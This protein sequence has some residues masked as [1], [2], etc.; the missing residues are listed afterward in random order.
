[1]DRLLHRAAERNTLLELDRDV[2]GQQLRVKVRIL[3][4]ADVDL[5][6]LADHFH[7]GVAKTV[8]VSAAATDDDARTRG[9]NVHADLVRRALDLDARNGG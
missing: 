2:L 7:D 9:V 5:Y 4:L 1:M 3:D 6:L 8:D